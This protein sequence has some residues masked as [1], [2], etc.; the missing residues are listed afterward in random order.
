MSETVQQEGV[1]SRIWRGL[2]KGDPAPGFDS[3][4]HLGERISLDKYSN[5]AVW[6]SF[7]RFAGCPTCKHFMQRMMDRYP[8]WIRDDFQIIVV[9]PSSIE[10]TLKYIAQEDHPF[11]LVCDQER[12]VFG[13]YGA[14]KT[15]IV[16]MLDPRSVAAMVSSMAQGFMMGRTDGPMGAVPCDFLIRPGGK[17]EVAHYGRHIGDHI[18]FDKVE[19]FLG[20]QLPA[21]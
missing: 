16:G 9:S 21:G 10:N 18:N 12:V 14:V 15:N 7:L 5:Q 17:I 20:I 19:Q 8:H 1:S 13:K 4:T 6:I 11:P 3:V 2:A